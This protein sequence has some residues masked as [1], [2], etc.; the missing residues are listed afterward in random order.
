MR[1]V[2]GGV[3]GLVGSVE[4]TTDVRGGGNV[5]VSSRSS[6]LGGEAGVAGGMVSGSAAV[7]VVVAVD[8]ECGVRISDCG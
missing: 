5:D 1:H 4:A 6:Y 8:I 3:W 2:R 7:I